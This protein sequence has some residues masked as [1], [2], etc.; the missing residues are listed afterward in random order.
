MSTRTSRGAIWFVLVAAGLAG[1]SGVTLIHQTQA[2]ATAAATSAAQIKA[3]EKDLTAVSAQQEQARDE[4]AARAAGM[5]SG[6]V[7]SGMARISADTTVIKGLLTTAVTWDSNASYTQAR[8]KLVTTY[9]VPA[10]S[11]FM[12]TFLPPAPYSV[13]STGKQYSYIDAAGL[14]SALGAYSVQLTG[15]RGTSYSYLVFVSVMASSTDGRGTASRADVLTLT[16]DADATVHDLRGWAAPAAVRDSKTE[17]TGPAAQ[18]QASASASAT[19]S[20]TR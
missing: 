16:V 14:N 11:A 5:P 19:A 2:D 12:T 9:K 6:N 3:L 1:A 15:V 17:L 10:D 8:A 4:A 7:A 18:A 20:P 13:D